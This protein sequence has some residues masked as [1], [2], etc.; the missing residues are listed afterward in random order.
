MITPLRSRPL[1]TLLAE[2]AIAA[3]QLGSKHARFR[4]ALALQDTLAECVS[5]DVARL[6]SA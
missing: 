1:T 3:M 5:G 6:E 4:Q 2:G